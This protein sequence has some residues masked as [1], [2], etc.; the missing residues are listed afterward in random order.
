MMNRCIAKRHV[1][2]LYPVLFVTILACA[3]RGP[4]KQKDITQYQLSDD[5]MQQLQFYN[6][7]PILLKRVRVAV[8]DS[9]EK[10]IKGGR[11]VE[12]QESEQE[13]ITVR[14]GTPGVIADRGSNWISINFGSGVIIPFYHISVTDKYM[15]YPLADNTIKIWERDFR[16]IS[17]YSAELLWQLKLKTVKKEHVKQRKAL[18]KKRIP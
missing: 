11:I 12:R 3:S 8:K 13:K 17:P 4:L 10:N 9:L 7:E 15:T 18:G 14:R 6:S 5:E 1:L 16:D 2:F